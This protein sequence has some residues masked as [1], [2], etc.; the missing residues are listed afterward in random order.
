[1]ARECKGA[2]LRPGQHH[3][4]QERRKRANATEHNAHSQAGSISQCYAR[5][6]QRDRLPALWLWMDR[7]SYLPNTSLHFCLFNSFS[8]TLEDHMVGGGPGLWRMANGAETP[9]CMTY[10]IIRNSEKE[11]TRAGLSTK[12]KLEHCI[13]ILYRTK[14]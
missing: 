14:F 11:G 3:L 12:G 8:V 10:A 1:M 4:T 13:R 2:L 6:G 7:C 5:S 9:R